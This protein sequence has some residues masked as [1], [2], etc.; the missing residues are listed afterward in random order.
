MVN[1]LAMKLNHDVQSTFRDIPCPNAPW[2]PK[3]RWP[4]ILLKP[5]VPPDVEWHIFQ[6]VWQIISKEIQ[7][8]GS[9]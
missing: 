7:V 6:Q 1:E 8:F 9:I 5:H 4:S 2:T 3:N